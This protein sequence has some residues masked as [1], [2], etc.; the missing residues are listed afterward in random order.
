[1][2]HGEEPSHVS[3]D[4]AGAIAD[5]TDRS[6]AKDKQEIIAEIKGAVREPKM[7]PTIPARA[8]DLILEGHVAWTEMRK[9][10]DGIEATWA[11]HGRDGFTTG[12]GAVFLDWCRKQPGWTWPKPKDQKS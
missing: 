9:M 2:D 10:L 3:A 8:A 5:L 12:P 7:N 11:K 4:L 6:K 1:M